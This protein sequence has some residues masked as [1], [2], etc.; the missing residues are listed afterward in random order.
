MFQLIDLFFI[1]WI[2]LVD[3]EGEVTGPVDLAVNLTLV[4]LIIDVI[5]LTISHIFKD[6]HYDRSFVPY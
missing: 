1:S 6:T 3:L 2:G 5:S 4:V